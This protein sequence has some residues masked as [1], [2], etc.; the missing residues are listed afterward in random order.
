MK[1]ILSF[2]VFLFISFYNFS[3]IVNANV[4]QAL[5]K[6]TQEEKQK[7]F[8]N[9]LELDS[10]DLNIFDT[11]D[12]AA[13]Y[14]K[15]SAKIAMKKHFLETKREKIIKRIFS[16]EDTI[17]KLDDDIEKLRQDIIETNKKKLKTNNSLKDIKKDILKLKFRLSK[18]KKVL[19]NYIVYLYKKDNLTKN[20]QKTDLLKTI[21]FSKKS[22]WEVFWW[23][24]F[25][26]MLKVTWKRIIDERKK[27]LRNLFLAQIK[28][29]QKQKKLNILKRNIL[30]SKWM[31]EDKKQ[32]KEE[33]L[34]E[35]KWKDS[36]YQKMIK[37]KLKEEQ[38]LKIFAIQEK[39]K[40]NNIKNNIFKKF[41]CKFIDLNVKPVSELN[42]LSSQKCRDLNKIMYAENLLRNY[43]K[44]WYE[45]NWP[46]VPSRWLAAY[47]MDPGYFK[48]LG[49]NHYAIDIRAYQ[50]TEIK[51]PADWYVVFIKPPVNRSYAY[52]AVK[53]AN[54]LTTVYWHISKVLVKKYDYV[55]EWQVIALSWWAAWTLWAW[56]ITSWP[57]LHFEVLKDKE[58]VDPLS[59]LNLAYLSQ[60]QIPDSKYINKY[61]DD[62]KK[63]FWVELKNFKKLYSLKS[64]K[65]IWKTEVE[66]QKYLLNKYAAKS[67]KNWNIWAEES[68]DWW[69][70]PSFVLCIWLAETWLWRHLKTRYNVWN[71]W[72]TDDGSVWSFS[73][74][75]EWIAWMVKT[76]NNKHLKKYTKVSQLSRFWNKKGLIYASSSFNWHN[77][78][79][80]CMWELKNEQLQT[81]FTFRI[82]N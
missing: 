16:L 30:V 78:I 52:M 5:E 66:R 20:W 57:H 38:K 47:F 73:S 48:A 37:D 25:D 9:P 24:N 45:L 59:Y 50:W 40:F 13:I 31:L 75:R 61:I 60:D 54:W 41:G 42:K 34:R 76:L 72:N 46:I 53:H 21:L 71:V 58:H 36:I 67:F 3:N 14:N 2:I 29:N 79:T 23:Q 6:F 70:D 56:Y 80:R 11:L 82:S 43:V 22:S 77:N 44:E 26:K 10:Q 12:K 15:L 7:I 49:W 18:N 28:L 63:T 74:P 19:I 39:L 17:K 35:S 1:K 4:W 81:D 68:L 62:Y 69:L 64:F 32:F 51:A 8:Q 33:L 27:I 55:K 65:L